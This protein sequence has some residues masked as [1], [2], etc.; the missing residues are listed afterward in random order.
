MKQKMAK[1]FWKRSLGIGLSLAMTLTMLP[2]VP[3]KAAEGDLIKA[4]SINATDS[5]V[6]EGQPFAAGTAGSTYF[7]I[8]AMIAT[9]NGN[10][11]AAADA[12]YETAGD[13][14]GLDTIASLSTDGGQTWKYSFPLYFPDSQGYAGTDATTIIDPVLVQ[15][16]DGAIYC[17]ADVNPTGV[18][19][20]G[21]FTSPNVGT[22][23]I[24]VDGKERLA[25]TSNYENVNTQP[26]AA[27]GETYEY[28][29]GDFDEEGYAPIV[30][31]SNGSASAYAVDRWY[32]LYSVKDGKYV[33]DLTQEQVNAD[34]QIQQN[35]FYRDSDLHVYNTGYLMY[36]KSTDDGL[37]WGDPEI[38]NPQIKRSNETGLLVS[39]GKGT[40]LSD[41]TIVIPFYE[42]G[43]GEENA[44]IIWSDDNGATWKRSA[45]VPGSANGG[46]WSSESEVVELNDGTL[47]MFFRSGQGMVCYADAVKN[48]SGEYEFA[49]PKR[50]SVACTSTCN[51]TASVYSEPIDGKQAI[52]VAMPGGAGRANGKVFTF[53]VD[54]EDGNKMTLKN[55]FSVPGSAGAY[56]YSCMDELPDGS[57]GLLWENGGASIRYDNFSIMDL[58]PNGYI[59]GA[60]IDLEMYR[61]EI[62]TRE[63]SVDADHMGI[64]KEPDASVA[65]ATIERGESMEKTVVPMYPHIA[66]NASSLT[67]F[68]TEADESLNLADAE[69]IITGEEGSYT[70]YNEF[71][72]KYL[73]NAAT[74]E[75]LSDTAKV[76]MKL[77]KDGD[78]EAF[79]TFRLEQSD[80]SGRFIIFFL[81]QMNFNLMSAYVSDTTRFIYDLVFLEKQDTESED[82]PIPGYKIAS[83]ITSGKNYLITYI[84]QEEEGNKFIILYPSTGDANSR[85]KLAG[86]AYR[87]VDSA[88]S[89][90]TITSVG[91]GETQAIIDGMV[92]NIKGLGNRK[93]NLVP[94][95]RYFIQGATEYSSADSSIASIETGTESRKALFDCER[96][97][98]H[99]LDGYSDEP[100][101]EIDMSGAEFI[102][103]S[104]EEGLYTIYSPTDEVYLVN[105]NAS[106]YFSASRATHSLSSSVKD[107]VTSFEICRDG[108][109]TQDGRYVYFFYER[110]GFDAVSAKPG[111]ETRGDFGFEFLEKSDTITNLD[112]IPGYRLA[113][114]IVPGNTYLITEYYEDGI[115]VLYPRNGIVNQSKLY[116]AVDVE[117]IYINALARG[118]QTTVTVDGVVYDVIIANDCTHNGTKYIEGSIKASCEKPGYTGDTYCSICKEKIG[119]GTEIPAIGHTWDDGEITKPVTTTED[120]EI[121]YTCVNDSS[122]TRT[123]TISSY[124]FAK[125]E[126]EKAISSAAG[127]AAQT[128]I[129]TESTLEELNKALSAAR[130]TFGNENATQAAIN[131]ALTNLTTAEGALVT[132]EMQEAID[133]LTQLVNQEWNASE[134]TEDTFAVLQS[135]IENGKN[136]LERGNATVRTLQNAIR[137]IESAAEALVNVKDVALA[138]A[139][140]K[141]DEKLAEAKKLV[142]NPSAYSAESYA[143]LK[144]AYDNAVATRNSEKVQA[145]KNAEAINAALAALNTAI[146]GLKAPQPAPPVDTKVAAPTIKSVSASAAKD[147]IAVNVTVN[148]VNGAAKYAVYR[149]VN[150]KTA[151]VGNTAAGKT[152]ITDKKLTGRKASYYAVALDASGKAI[153]DNGAAKAI[154]LESAIKIKKVS[155]SKSN[156]KI[157]WNKGKSATGYIVYRSTKKNGSYT[158]LA[159]VKKNKTSYTDKKAAK[160]KTYYYKV[161]YK[162]KKGI[163]VMSAASKKAKRKK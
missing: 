84:H 47:R 3:G 80:G 128:D 124:D 36:A 18:T 112:P 77:A 59:P 159:A 139:N 41:G 45:D 72:G 81:D 11:L 65:E 140:A 53:L 42:H 91:E 134:Y 60:E 138:E 74:N 104:P 136:L 98:N 135:A 49:A 28:Y 118:K 95:E 151:L 157:T 86:E 2:A 111:F 88:M 75:V 106:S 32:N 58:V 52:L 22:G 117:G 101:W 126:L 145:D 24:T 71:S 122:H 105:T 133:R 34:T 19:T 79:P 131:E 26:T 63:Y 4:G 33:A 73:T 30:N 10:L 76:H 57:I 121:T 90:L 37:T 48:G 146:S 155:S 141:L 64:Q 78:Q 35:V 93:V 94:G 38:L 96:E 87:K 44:S 137:R 132:K 20:M 27:D 23:Y 51:V 67:S 162:T 161:V 108:N 149:V 130:S 123:E 142:D 102:V 46:F 21:G 115:I 127:K 160:G 143:V 40:L 9:Q 66:D 50:T 82:D 61:G 55:T 68:S 92:Y 14:G 129:Y 114:E 16:R 158:K 25:I 103:D 70:V 110:M 120:G 109:G 113:T 69:W 150:G 152:S 8:P 119:N 29:V 54:A 148:A 125:S 154:T 100:N 1:H 56:Q 99:N 43:D 15:G 163:S 147:G 39:P 5:S 107:G 6:T 144:S 31:R 12:R 85:T 97:S 62:Y 89:T 153:S 13:G 17:M 7:R 156:I 116:Q 83:E